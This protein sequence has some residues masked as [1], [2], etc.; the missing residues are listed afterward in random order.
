MVLSDRAGQDRRIARS[1]RAAYPTGRR[2]TRDTTHPGD[3]RVGGRPYADAVPATENHHPAPG[4]WPSGRRH[5]A[6]GETGL[7]RGGLGGSDQ[8]R[9]APGGEGELRGPAGGRRAGA[10][11]VHVALVVVALASM[12]VAS[13]YSAMPDPVAGL[14]LAW[15]AAGVACGTGV[16]S[17]LLVRGRYP[18]LVAV[19][20][21]VYAML[22]PGGAFV[23]LVG[24]ASV[25]AT[26]PR[27]QAL[28]VGAMVGAATG[29]SVLRDAL[30]PAAA[31]IFSSTQPVG[32]VVA[33]PVW[34][35][36]LVFVVSLG[37]AVGAGLYRR[38]RRDL[39]EVRAES[40][41][42]AQ[43]TEHLRTELTR[44]E[45]RDLI[46]REVHDTLAHR[47]SLVSLQA[48]ALEVVAAG[49]PELQE[50]ASAV[51]A[52]AHRSLDDLRGL[53]GVLRDPA[54]VRTSA[55]EP[56]VQLSLDD[57]AELLTTT[58]EAGTPVVATVV[59]SDATSASAPFT[60]AVYRIVQESL[61][62]ASKHAPGLH[63][64]VALT[65]SAA[66][67]LHLRVSNPLPA[68]ARAGGVPGSGAG[69]TGIHERVRLLGGRAQV[70]PS[71][72]HFVV[73]VWL[74][75]VVHSA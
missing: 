41:E 25:V 55:T 40:H 58:R 36:P 16:A 18:V 54:T 52:N 1:G 62:N 50:A 64:D 67:G 11:A 5:G 57:L 44:Q 34:S 4:A 65:A 15:A 74:P 43:T 72:G 14:R 2:T 26:R 35:H 63:L 27:R 32:E 75:W 30:R 60:H 19:V 56:P 20:G 39:T 45:E 17:L 68:Q 12:L 13:S 7:G 33:A 22:L 10:V 51:Q 28:L 46:A 29:V 9:P 53:I 21:S 61:T 73:D 42:R 69:V 23:A 47:L 38:A 48:G 3:D 8:T 66:S 70:G 49:D 37:A 31:Q 24:L 71:D 6:L 59:V